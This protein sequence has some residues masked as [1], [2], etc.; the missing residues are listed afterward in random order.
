MK[1]KKC[2]KK[3]VKCPSCKGA[4]S[5]WGMFGGCTTCGGTGYACGQHGKNWH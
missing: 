2:G 3:V 5:V 4:G 1:C